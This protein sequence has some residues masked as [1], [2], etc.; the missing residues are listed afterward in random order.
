MTS[1]RNEMPSGGAM[2]AILRPMGWTE[3]CPS[4]AMFNPCVRS[5]WPSEYREHVADC[6]YCQRMVGLDYRI[7]CPGPV[8]LAQY[9]AR[10]MNAKAFALHLNK[11]KCPKCTAALESSPVVALLVRIMNA[12]Q[13]LA[14]AAKAGW[15]APTKVADWLLTLPNR[16]RVVGLPL[17]LLVGGAGSLH[18]LPPE[19]VYRE[20]ASVDDVTAEIFADEEDFEVFVSADSNSESGFVITPDGE[21]Y[22]F[23]LDKRGDKWCGD[24]PLDPRLATSVTKLP[25]V[26]ILPPA[27]SSFMEENSHA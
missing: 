10:S 19:E 2:A 20:T 11:D 1:Q 22:K 13:G 5:G 12:T 8:A 16:A 15:L 7:E 17:P 23:E 18:F 24:I 4:I 6:D 14:T 21:G 9:K 26:V 25:V 3:R 27:A